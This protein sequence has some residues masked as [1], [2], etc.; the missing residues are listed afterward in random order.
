MSLLFTKSKICVNVLQSVVL[1]YSF[2]LNK[3][4]T[5]FAGEY[6]CL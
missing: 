2:I 5:T 1:I 3:T 4:V 6:L